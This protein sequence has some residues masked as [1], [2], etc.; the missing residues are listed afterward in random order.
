MENRKTNSA[1]PTNKQNAFFT[2]KPISI[3]LPRP[4]LPPKRR[5]PKPSGLLDN[6]YPTLSKIY[7]FPY[8][9]QSKTFYLVFPYPLH[10]G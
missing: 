10:I 1:I 9:E 5:F 8:H 2:L 6:V 7:A 3:P 4:F